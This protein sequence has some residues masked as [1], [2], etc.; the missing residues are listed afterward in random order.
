VLR[1]FTF[2]SPST[3]R[4]L[5]SIPSLCYCHQSIFQIQLKSWNQL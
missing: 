4:F 1:S 2:D 5:S 3:V